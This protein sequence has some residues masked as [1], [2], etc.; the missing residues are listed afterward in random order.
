M[1]LSVELGVED[2]SVTLLV[3]A[4]EAVVFVV[5]AALL[6][7]VLFDRAPVGVAEERLL[8]VEALS[9]ETTPLLLWEVRPEVLCAAVFPAAVP[10][11]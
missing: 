4:A 1:L 5:E 11:R 6:V 3:F 7:A 2:D 8:V 9:V 10:C